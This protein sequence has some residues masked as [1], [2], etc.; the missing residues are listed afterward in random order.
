MLAAF[1]GML[2]LGAV[3][4]IIKEL[5]DYKI[6]ALYL[7]LDVRSSAKIKECSLPHIGYAS[8][9]YIYSP[10]AQAVPVGCHPIAVSI[11][12]QGQRSRESLY[13]SAATSASRTTR[14]DSA[15]WRRLSAAP[16]SFFSR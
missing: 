7:Y 12:L 3:P 16:K 9:S 4:C 2:T 6:T 10:E 8:V 13:L 5:I 1:A 14:S 11:S 15:C